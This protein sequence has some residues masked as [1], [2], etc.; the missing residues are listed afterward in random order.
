MSLIL[1]P[2]TR[3]AVLGLLFAHSELSLKGTSSLW[4]KAICSFQGGA[5]QSLDPTETN[6]ICFNILIN[7]E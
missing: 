1:S 4:S 3:G 7:V 6:Q 2:G 5:T